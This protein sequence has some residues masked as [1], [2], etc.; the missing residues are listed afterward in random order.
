M[1]IVSIQVQAVMSSAVMYRSYKNSNDPINVKYIEHVFTSISLSLL[2]SV[3]LITS[4]FVF[5]LVTVV[6]IARRLIALVHI[7][8]VLIVLTHAKHLTR[9]VQNV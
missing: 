4:A 5:A 9:G 8:L 2:Y 7:A 6:L 3:A 1:V